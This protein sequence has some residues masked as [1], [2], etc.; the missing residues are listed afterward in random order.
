MTDYTIRLATAADLDAITALGRKYLLNGPYKSQLTDNPVAV[1]EF[2]ARVLSGDLSLASCV[3]AL[4]VGGVVVGVFCFII[5]PH[6]YGGD[7]VASEMIWC[8]EEEYRRY[9][10]E[11]LWKAEAV[12]YAMGAK[13][14]ALTA[15]TEKVGE[16]YKRLKG[17]S[18]VEV[19]YQA[20]LSERVT[21][22]S[23]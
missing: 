3:L 6:Y 23:A 11:L 20:T 15:P 19:G 9:S 17:Y 21:H 2:S 10:L 7:L 5:Y 13:R 1:R 14:M 12:A 18:L 8:V 4:E 16:L 22:A